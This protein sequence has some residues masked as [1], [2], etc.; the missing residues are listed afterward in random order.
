MRGYRRGRC[1]IRDIDDRVAEIQ[2]DLV[3][4]ALLRVLD[5]SAAGPA[6]AG[7]VRRIGLLAFARSFC[8][9]AGRRRTQYRGTDVLG[10]LSPESLLGGDRS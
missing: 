9:L 1:L 6:G 7:G 4:D 5:T 10:N 3:Y 8:S 2:I